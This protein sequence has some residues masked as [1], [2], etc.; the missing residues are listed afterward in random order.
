MVDVQ[1]GLK[2]LED[3]LLPLELPVSA[4]ESLMPR[5]VDSECNTGSKHERAGGALRA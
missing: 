4:L 5:R 2:F 3:P 1:L